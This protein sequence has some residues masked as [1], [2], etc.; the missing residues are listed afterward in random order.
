VISLP[1]R[2][3]AAASLDEVRAAGERRRAA[4]AE[5]CAA[6]RRHHRRRLRRM[7]AWGCA[8]GLAGWL[9][10]RFALA[11]GWGGVALG[12]LAMGATWWLCAATGRHL[13]GSMV[14]SSVLNAVVF[15]AVIMGGWTLESGLRGGIA[16]VFVMIGIML[17]WSV[18]GAV[19][20]LCNRTWDLDHQQIL[21]D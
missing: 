13:L 12:T 8:C 6:W 19:V 14:V 2:L 17:S 21:A 5:R 18:V 11:I 16:S 3:R 7:F 1:P 20:G 10:L 4:Q 9:L 15:F